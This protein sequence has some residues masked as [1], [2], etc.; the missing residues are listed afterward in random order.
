MITWDGLF[1]ECYLCLFTYVVLAEASREVASAQSRVAEKERLTYDSEH[2]ALQRD[3]QAGSDR[4]KEAADAARQK[5]D[6]ERCAESAQE[7]QLEANQHLQLAQLEVARLKVSHAACSVL[8]HSVKRCKLIQL[9]LCTQG[10]HFVAEVNTGHA[11]H[12]RSAGK[13]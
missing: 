12:S 2:L 4:W 8:L 13:Q 11:S 10:S 6:A 5:V 7:A 9:C 3:S 1:N